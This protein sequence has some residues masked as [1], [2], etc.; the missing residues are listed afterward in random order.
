MVQFYKNH[1]IEVSVW[2]NGEGWFINVFIYYREDAT[3]VLVT[4]AVNEKFTTYDEA[5]EA[6]VAAARS[7]IDDRV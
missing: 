4:F 1:N 2:H 3:N 6:G 5:I 7:W